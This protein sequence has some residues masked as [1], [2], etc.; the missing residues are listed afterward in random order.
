MLEGAASPGTMGADFPL[1][2]QAPPDM[3]LRRTHDMKHA[4][5]GLDNTPDTE[6]AH[7]YPLE[8]C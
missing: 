3:R 2:D 6:V 8:G 4:L 1:Q 5:T 7:R